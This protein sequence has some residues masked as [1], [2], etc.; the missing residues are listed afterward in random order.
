[1][2]MKL[3]WIRLKSNIHFLH[4]TLYTL[5]I[6]TIVTESYFIVLVIRKICRMTLSVLEKNE[7]AD[8]DELG[9]IYSIVRSA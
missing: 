4:I 7:L 1:M 9:S 2:Y 3:Q 8:M 5:S 6:L